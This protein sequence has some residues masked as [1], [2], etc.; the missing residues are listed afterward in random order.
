MERDK[1]SPSLKKACSYLSIL[2]RANP[3][4]YRIISNPFPFGRTLS[5]E[6]LEEQKRQYQRFL[7]LQTLRT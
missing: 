7:L 1:D 3:L 2:E 6:E 4:R 5:P